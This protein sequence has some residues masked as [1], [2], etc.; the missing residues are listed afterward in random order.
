[1]MY[2]AN[3]KTGRGDPNVEFPSNPGLP[4]GT[5]EDCIGMAPP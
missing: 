5:V 1:M 4:L 3:A 2:P